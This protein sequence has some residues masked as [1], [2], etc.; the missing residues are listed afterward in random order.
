MRII[1]RKC[2]KKNLTKNQVLEQE[3]IL[4][5]YLKPL[6]LQAIKMSI[7]AIV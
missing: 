4:V 3:V 1:L 6:I 5:D 2:P 7:N